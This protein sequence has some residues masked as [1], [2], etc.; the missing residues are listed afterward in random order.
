M[1][2]PLCFLIVLMN[3]KVTEIGPIEA[4]KQ[5]LMVLG[6]FWY[7]DDDQLSQFAIPRNLADNQAESLRA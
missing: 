1:L 4:T 6:Y 2:F 7:C 5:H 3:R